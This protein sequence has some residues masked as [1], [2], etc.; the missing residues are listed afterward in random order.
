MMFPTC[1]FSLIRTTVPPLFFTNEIVIFMVCWKNWTD[2]SVQ[3]SPQAEIGRNFR[4][5][6]GNWKLDEKI[7]RKIG[8]R[9]WIRSRPH[10][11]VQTQTA[12]LSKWA[13][14]GPDWPYLGPGR[15]NGRH[16]LTEDYPGHIWAQG[17]IYMR[18]GS[19]PIYICQLRLP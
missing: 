2:N 18:Q 17:A 14:W 1:P 5:I 7:G 4:P 3:F 12:K 11:E 8:L 10:T 19:M 6:T 15:Q 9:F 13:S 16:E